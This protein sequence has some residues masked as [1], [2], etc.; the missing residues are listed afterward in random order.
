MDRHTICAGLLVSAGI[1]LAAP[2]VHA[3]QPLQIGVN[4]S[5]YMEISGLNRVAVGN[6]EVAD[7]QLVSGNELLVIGKKAGSTTL[8]VWGAGGRSEYLVIV[9]GADTGLAEII[10]R[11]IGL[12]GV[13]VQTVKDKV[14]LKFYVTYRF[15][16]AVK[17]KYNMPCSHY[18]KNAPFQHFSLIP[19][20]VGCA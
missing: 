14:L 5:R 10:Q 2:A 17:L 3:A 8:L 9:S 19:D 11:A 1:L 18:F 4:E 16:I 7:V 6:P 15:I 20:H 13:T 12:P